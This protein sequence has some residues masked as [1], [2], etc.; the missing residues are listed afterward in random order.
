MPETLD[1]KKLP[2]NEGGDNTYPEPDIPVEDAWDNMKQLLQQ[3]PVAPGGKSAL[4]AGKG[5]LFWGAAGTGMVAI[6]AL[7]TYVSVGKKET[8]KDKPAPAQTIHNSNKTPKIDTLHEGSI[9]YINN[10]IFEFSNTPFKEA[11]AFIE[12]AYGVTIVIKNNKLYNCTVTTKF[13]NRSLEEILDILGYTL[14][15]EYSIDKNKNQVIISG[16]GCNH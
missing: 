2:K 5:K 10:R 9:A 13:D 3:A 12:K 6:V 11:A 7:T 16:D 4:S 14:T 1:K 15:F 8:E